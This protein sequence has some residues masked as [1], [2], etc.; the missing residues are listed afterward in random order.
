VLWDSED[1]V[2]CNP[3]RG[4]T[5]HFR[6]SY[7]EVD[8]FGAVGPTSAFLVYGIAFPVPRRVQA[9][10][11]PVGWSETLAPFRRAN[12]KEIGISKIVKKRK[13]E[14]GKSF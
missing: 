9:D 7:S 8:G 10:W 14:P 13:S 12:A 11:V 4:A 6:I 3:N 1:A 5:P 2:P